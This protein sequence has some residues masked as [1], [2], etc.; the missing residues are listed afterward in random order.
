M[1]TLTTRTVGGP[2]GGQ[3]LQ[4]F[5]AS[6]AD[7]AAAVI[8]LH[9]RGASAQSMHPLAEALG[10]N[11]VAYV[12]PQAANHTWYPQ[13]FLAP[14]EANQPWLDSALAVVHHLIDALQDEGIGPERIVL[15]GF[16]QGACLATEAAA[17]KPQRYGGVV[18]FSGGLIGAADK[19]EGTPPHDKVLS[20]DGS[21]DGTPVLLGC[22][23]VDAHIPVERV[24]Q[25]ADALE[26][27]G[28]AVD[29]RIYPGMGH[30]IN[31]DELSAAR[32]L[33]QGVISQQG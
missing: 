23:D 4:T 10:T 16:S 27:L 17:R 9:G 21:L 28:A 25:T 14:L 13:S 11:D 32:D 22:S 31:D 5:G 30:T 3:P 18:G 7:A 12:A 20:Y 26:Q 29:E 1:S 15:L 8:L 2:H 24:H 19:E 33:L 6:R